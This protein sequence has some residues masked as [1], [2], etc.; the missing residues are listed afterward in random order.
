MILYTDPPRER[1]IDKKRSLLSDV[2]NNDEGM[3]IRKIAFENSMDIYTVEEKV[4][5][6]IALCPTAEKATRENIYSWVE[7]NWD[8]YQLVSF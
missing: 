1:K 2:S 8:N 5:Y 7:E 3:F 6:M 4:R